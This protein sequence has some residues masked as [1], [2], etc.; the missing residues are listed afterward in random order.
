MTRITGKLHGNLYTFMMIY[1]RILFS[2]R[3]VSDKICKEDQDT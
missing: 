2:M 1:R 3:N